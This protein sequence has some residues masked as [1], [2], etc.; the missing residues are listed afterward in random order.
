M[1]TS[2]AEKEA[3]RAAAGATGMS[4][5]ARMNMRHSSVGELGHGQQLDRRVSHSGRPGMA[6]AGFTGSSPRG[7][8]MLSRRSSTRSGAGDISPIAEGNRKASMRNSPMSGDISPIVEGRTVNA[9]SASSDH[10]HGGLRG[11]QASIRF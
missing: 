2:E 1:Q 10:R 4:L 5:D 6:R 8:V 9:P 7:S 11:R 3:E